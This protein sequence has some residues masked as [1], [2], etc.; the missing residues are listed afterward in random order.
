[1]QRPTLDQSDFNIAGPTTVQIERHVIKYVYDTIS[2]I[3]EIEW[4]TGDEALPDEAVDL[5][6][7]LLCKDQRNRLGTEGT[8]FIRRCLYY[9]SELFKI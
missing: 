3:G 8:I 2:F 1:M 9:L 4:P 6:K 5:V 7:G